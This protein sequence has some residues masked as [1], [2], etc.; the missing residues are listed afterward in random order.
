MLYERAA[1]SK[2]PEADPAGAKPA[3]LTMQ[4]ADVGEVI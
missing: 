1:L 2:Q 4:D 3:F